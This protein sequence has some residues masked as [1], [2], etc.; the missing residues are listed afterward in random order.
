MR[1]RAYARQRVG[2]K[3]STIDASAR[4]RVRGHFASDKPTCMRLRLTALHR[5]ALH[6]IINKLGK[7]S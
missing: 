6:R 4:R 7:Q 3:M 1:R 5:Q 2:Q